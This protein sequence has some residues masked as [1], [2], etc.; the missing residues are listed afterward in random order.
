LHFAS[1]YGFGTDVSI[2]LNRLYSIEERQAVDI[3]SI[4]EPGL[5]PPP[6]TELSQPST[7][8]LTGT[9]FDFELG[10]DDDG[11][12]ADDERDSNQVNDSVQSRKVKSNQ[13]P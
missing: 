6:R 3:D 8:D 7:S 13:P 10:G 11:S 12:E 4:H 9:I 5:S 2:R 1:I